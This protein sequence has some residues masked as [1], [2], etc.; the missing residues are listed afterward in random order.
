MVKI[1][2]FDLAVD[3]NIN[4]QEQR[5]FCI[6]H[7]NEICFRWAAPEVVEE[8]RFSTKSDV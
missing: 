8:N 6:S 7:V 4:V 3:M 1:C 5:D 2:D